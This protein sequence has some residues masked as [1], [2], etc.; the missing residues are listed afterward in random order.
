MSDL[1]FMFP[2]QSSR[3]P[4]MI[5]KLTDEHESARQI[6][7]RASDILKRDLAKHYRSSNPA[8]FEINRDVQ[9]GMFLANHMHLTLLA[10]AGVKAAWSLGLSLGEYNHLVHIGALSFD[11]GVTLVDRRGQLFDEGP[12]G[13]MVSLFPIEAHDL[14][15]IIADLNLQERVDVG[16]YNS[17][18]QQVLS[19]ER[20]AVEAVLAKIEDEMFADATE[21]ESRIPMHSPLFASVGKA[22]KTVLDGAP[23]VAPKLAYVPNV[24]GEVSEAASPPFIRECLAA[25]VFNPVRWQKSVEAVAS[26]LTDPTFLEVGPRAVLYNLIGR[27]WTPGKRAKTDSAKDGSGHFRELVVSLGHGS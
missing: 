6:V 16:L 14:E 11:D 20:A 26:K 4:E 18:R 9:I 13:V 17:P 1:V 22:L 15:A 21:I 3:Y 12:H 7:S 5:E 19:G 2:G 24:R 8:I 23:F 25:H 10:D 27:G